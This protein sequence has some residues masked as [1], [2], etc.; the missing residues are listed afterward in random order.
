[1]TFIL[2]LEIELIKFREIRWK[3][4]K[5]EE[6]IC[7]CVI[8]SRRI[9]FV[10]PYQLLINVIV[11]FDRVTIKEEDVESFGCPLFADIL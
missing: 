2:L 9:P 5:Q 8:R 7:A 11:K 6:I 3:Y 10:A 4:S 1:M